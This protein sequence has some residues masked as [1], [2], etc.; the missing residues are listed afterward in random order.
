MRSRDLV[1]N[2]LLASLPLAARQEI[3]VVERLFDVLTRC[4]RVCMKVL[5]PAD[6]QRAVVSHQTV[7]KSCR[8]RGAGKNAGGILVQPCLGDPELVHAA[9]AQQVRQAPDKRAARDL[10]AVQAQDPVAAALREKP[11]QM[12]LRQAELDPK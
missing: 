5:Q 7:H 8:P 3:E 10:V 12:A 9:G 4:D 6:T 2:G 1:S 11:T